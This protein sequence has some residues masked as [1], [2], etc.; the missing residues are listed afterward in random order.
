M[1]KPFGASRLKVTIGNA[2]RQEEL[3]DLERREGV[4]RVPT[5]ALSPDN[6]VLVLDEVQP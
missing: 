5:A 1:T 2:I 3:A 4:L 6:T